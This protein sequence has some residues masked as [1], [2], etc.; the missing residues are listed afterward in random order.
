M[1]AIL[2]LSDSPV[3]TV[4]VTDAP[5]DKL[6]LPPPRDALFGWWIAD[7]VTGLAQNAPLATLPD[8]SG[9]G[10]DFV[11]SGANRP[12]F[13][14]DVVDGRSAIYFDGLTSFMTLGGSP[15]LKA[16]CTVLIVWKP[17]DAVATSQALI[18]K[19]TN[20]LAFLNINT[21]TPSLS[22]LSLAKSGAVYLANQASPGASAWQI[23]AFTYDGGAHASIYRNGYL[24]A[25][26]SS[27][28]GSLNNNATLVLGRDS[29]GSAANG[30]K[31][32]VAEMLIYSKVQS[33]DE[34]A[35]SHGW[36]NGGYAGHY[37]HIFAGFSSAAVP[38]E[39]LTAAASVDGIAWDDLGA[40]YAELVNAPSVRFA[41][42]YYWLM[43]STAINASPDLT[44]IHIRKTRDF[45]TFTAVA[46]LDMGPS[47]PSLAAVWGP[48]LF[49]DSDGTVY[50]LFAGGIGG[51]TNFN[52]Y[53]IAATDDTLATWGAPVQITVSGSPNWID[54]FPVKVGS[55]YYLFGKNVTG[56]FIELAVGPAL[57]GP[58]T[59]V[60]S[61][62]WAGWGLDVEGECLTQIDGGWRIY[63]D[64]YQN[65]NTGMYYSE[66]EDLLEPWS[67]KALTTPS[68]FRHG[69]VIRKLAESMF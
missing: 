10:R 19:Q 16:G 54:P 36:L 41:N 12:A 50:I 68:T 61:G 34:L 18:S 25:S 28:A 8:A 7:R 56:K 39:S 2:T 58:Y 6:I 57:L 38:L 69:T 65:G 60:R 40:S 55:T 35:Q 62:D 49:T 4:S 15:N 53:A 67:P 29:V 27:F 66:S 52:Q 9:N 13:Q 26:T 20:D 17:V 32:W 14:L 22:G 44:V 30:L 51:H 33:A 11:A 42:G 46:S 24:L 3:S 59:V 47:I 23:A 48:E 31:G 37:K 64:K 21:A 45:I 43:H 5:I 1:T 63:M